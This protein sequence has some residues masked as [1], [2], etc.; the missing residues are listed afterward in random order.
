MEK[1]EVFF[2]SI[3]TF[4]T[5][6]ALGSFF[7]PMFAPLFLLG[8]AFF[9]GAGTVFRSWNVF[10]FGC[11]MLVFLG[12]VVLASQARDMYQKL[13]VLTTTAAGTVRIVADPV[14]KDFFRNI[15]LRFESCESDV[16]PKTDVLWQAPLSFR[17]EAGTRLRFQC[18]LE[19][20][21]NFTPEFDYRMFLHKDGIGYVCPKAS[22]VQLLLPD[23][24]SFIRAALYVPKHVFEETLSRVLREPE[25][26]L[27]KGLLLGGDNYLP[28]DL[29]DSFTRVGLSHMIAVSGYNITLIAQML[30]SLGLILGLWRKQSIWFALI[31][32]VFFIVMIGLPASAARAG[33]MASIVFLALQ[34]GRLAR[35]VNAL[36]FAGA[37]MLLLNPLLF[38]YDLGF[39]LSFLATLGILLLMPYYEHFSPKQVI[40]K[41]GGEILFMTIAVELFVLPLILFSFHT[42]SPLIIIGNFLVVLVPFA[43]A[44]S[45]LAGIAFLIIPGAHVVFAWMALALLTILTR[46]VEVLGTLTR[47]TVTVDSF[48]VWHLVGWYVILGTLLWIATKYFPLTR[49]SYEEKS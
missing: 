8:G 19:L 6:I 29:K 9:L 11:F 21:K 2:L 10:F 46:S 37:A 30:L 31:G 42:F 45:F 16:C 28:R 43:M 33:T 35:P 34:S 41:K 26:G 23:R 48:G 4:I 49:R 5:G 39:Q 22:A 15:V 32:I 47:V 13:P 25:A 18:Q 1:D 7:A 17:G 36:L 44:A 40:L 20:P 14:E 24:E 3:L 12:G 38:R 27:A